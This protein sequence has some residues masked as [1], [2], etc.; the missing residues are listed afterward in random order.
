MQTHERYIA[1]VAKLAIRYADLSPTE[2]EQ[3]KAIKLVY[4][5]GPNG[6]RGVTY[7]N[8]FKPAG[9]ETQVPFVE[10]C[11]FS[12]ESIVQVTG[13]TLH[14]LGHVL[15]GWGEGHGKQ[16]VCSCERLGLKGIKAAGTEY[17]WDMFAPKLRK[18][19]E[20]LPKPD[21]GEILPGLSLGGAGLGGMPTLKP[22]GAGI[23]T[24]GGKSRGVGS[25]SRLRKYVCDCGQI[26]RAACDDLDA[27]HNECKTAFVCQ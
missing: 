4:G 14:E 20:K 24:R 26:V 9:S 12:Q 15:A 19:I 17:A 10:I 22:C 5:A 2:R 25:G 8:R 23:G 7:Y 13:T 18:A 11:A 1:S 6:V 21:E 16:W 3:L 27:V